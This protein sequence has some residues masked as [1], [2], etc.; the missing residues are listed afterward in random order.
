MQKGLNVGAESLRTSPWP[1][2]FGRKEVAVVRPIAI[3]FP[4]EDNLRSFPWE[5]RI[6]NGEPLSAQ[7]LNMNR[8]WHGTIMKTQ[9]GNRLQNIALAPG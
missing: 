2:H 1:S 8:S 6:G 3:R 5:S 4:S 9:I 7:I